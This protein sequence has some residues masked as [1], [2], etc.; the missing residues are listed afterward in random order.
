MDNCEKLLVDCSSLFR[1]LQI[2]EQE[3]EIIPRGNHFGLSITSTDLIEQRQSFVDE[4]VFT[5]VDWVFSKA[6]QDHFIAE[7]LAEGDTEG[8]I[9]GK[10]VRSAKNRF[11]TTSEP[12]LIKGQFGELV[13]FCCLQHLFKAVPL[14]RKMPI[15]TN[16]RLERN[17][18]DAIHYKMEEGEHLFYLGE[19][20][21]YAQD[22][23]F[24]KAFEASIN[25]ILT[26][27]STH[28]EEI[29]LYRECG[30]LDPELAEIARLYK[31]NQLPNAKVR[32]VC[33]V[34]YN[35]N[36]LLDPAE[37]PLDIAE[38]AK[39][40]LEERF[41][42]FPNNK[43]INLGKAALIQRITYIVFPVR[44]LENLL[45]LFVETL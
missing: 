3:F 11:R 38:H 39:N 12:D 40:I 22:Y 30:F 9:A 14:L 5:V 18:A 16:P 4:L 44:D 26:E 36:R 33:Q 45:E 31:T 2:I 34:I 17:G 27:H 29:E 13:L 37:T 35:E 42:S 25:S 10:L 41:A 21:C 1:N 15:T 32:L 28:M 43:I 20:K 24:S 8:R 7:K 19:S 6:Q 23:G